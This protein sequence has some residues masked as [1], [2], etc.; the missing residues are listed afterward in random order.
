MDVW[1]WLVDWLRFLAQL[2]DGSKAEWLSATSAMIALF[3]AFFAVRAAHRQNVVQAAQLKQIA[4]EK[5]REQAEKIAAWYQ[6]TG[7]HGHSIKIQNASNLPIY[8]VAVWAV[9][10]EVPS[11]LFLATYIY[12]SVP[13]GLHHC[14]IAPGGYLEAE[15]GDAAIGVRRTP[16]VSMLFIDSGARHYARGYAGV[17]EELAA[18]EW[19]RRYSKVAN[20]ATVVQNEQLHVS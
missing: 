6:P 19:T 15:T 1:P 10:A 4:D 17:L 12:D 14:Y 3:F 13:P 9:A 2:E 5:R 20:R 16:R 11:D 7:S 8:S 18:D